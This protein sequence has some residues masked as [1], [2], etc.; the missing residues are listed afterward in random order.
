MIDA[1]VST[2]PDVREERKSIFLLG[3]R[4]YPFS[5][6]HFK[7]K[8]KSAS[9]EVLWKPPHGR[10]T[11]IPQSQLI[12]DGLPATVVVSTTFPADDRSDGYE[13]GTTI[14]KEWD[15]AT[16]RAAIEVAAHVEKN[17]DDLTGTRKSAQ[18]RTDKL[19]DF[20]RRFV[21]AA[22]RRPL[23]EE[24]SQVFVER[25]FEAA[26]DPDIAVKRVVL[27]ALKS[28]RFL[29]PELSR[30]ENADDFSVAT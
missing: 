30:G 23:A 13:R 25:Q 1:W 29:Y 27:L 24:Q 22:F 20:A 8:D 15:Q 21:E 7:Y 28:P 16:T 4:S 2:G 26:S 18:D 17:L 19:K 6:E 3:G 14:S 12:P 10:E 11:I 9:I 5:V